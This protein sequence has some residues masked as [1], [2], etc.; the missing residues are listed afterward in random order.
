MGI[1][2]SIIIPVY[3]TAH[4]LDRCLRSITDQQPKNIEIVIVDDGSVDGS[5]KLCDQWAHTFPWIH[6]IHQ[7][8]QGVSAARNKGLSIAAG[9]FMLFVDADDWLDY[10]TI[11]TLQES[12]SENDDVVVFD[13]QEIDEDGMVLHDSHSSFPH[14]EDASGLDSLIWLFQGKYSWNVWQMLIRK[15]AFNGNLRFPEDIKMAEDLYVVGRLL[16]SAEHVRFIP[17]PL[18]SYIKREGSAMEH[19]FRDEQQLLQTVKDIVN[20][21]SGL[22]EIYADQQKLYGIWVR[23]VFWQYFILIVEISAHTQLTDDLELYRELMER[24]IIKQRDFLEMK[25][26]TV[27]LRFCF[28]RYNLIHFHLLAKAC[29]IYLGQR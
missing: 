28:I 12:V 6:V 10:K 25:R 7:T 19:R 23:Q 18:Y 5:A 3:N 26:I 22:N 14:S 24:F 8:N 20:V 9:E 1:K 2:I 15:T 17:C 21:E 4:H 29:Q 16:Y 13:Y 11:R 27:F